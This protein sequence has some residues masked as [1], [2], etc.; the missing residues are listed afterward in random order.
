MGCGASKDENPNAIK[1]DFDLT[2]GAQTDELF[3]KARE[4][5]EPAEEIR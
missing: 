1:Y 3:R 4:I 5:L 2:G